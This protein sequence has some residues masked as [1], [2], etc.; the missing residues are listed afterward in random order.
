MS[1][2]DSR[3]T[4]CCEGDEGMSLDERIQQLDERI[5][6]RFKDWVKD[7]HE[8][9]SQ[10]L[11]DEIARQLE[12]A[13]NQV[14]EGLMDLEK[15]QSITAVASS[16]GGELVLRNL[17]SAMVG[18]DRSKKQAD[19]LQALLEGAGAF[20]S[21][22]AIFLTRADQAS[23]W[24]AAGFGEGDVAI[25]GLLVEYQDDGPWDRLSQGRSSIRLSAADCGQ[26]CSRIEA[27]LPGNGVLIPLVLRDR[28]AAAL[29]AD[30]LQDDPG[31]L[32]VEG[33]QLLAYAAAQ[34]IENLPFHQRTSTTP[35]LVLDGDEEE[36]QE[37]L[38]LWEGAAAAVAVSEVE[39]EPTEVEVAIEADTVADTGVDLDLDIETDKELGASTDRAEES[40]PAY[41]DTQELPY[42]PPVGEEEAESEAAPP[43]ETEAAE[44]VV[45]EPA[46]SDDS[47]AE[48]R[49]GSA[50][51]DGVST[52]KAVEPP[53]EAGRG[54]GL[55]WTEDDDVAEPAEEVEDAW[56]VDVTPEVE[57]SEPGALWEVEEEEAEAKVEVIPEAE[58]PPPAPS[59]E[60]VDEPSSVQ[61]VSEAPGLET[62]QAPVMTSGADASLLE[63]DATVFLSR[64]PASPAPRQEPEEAEDEGDETHPG[65][66]AV[67]DPEPAPAPPKP[68]R[69]SEVQPPADVEGPGWAFSKDTEKATDDDEDHKQAKRLARLLVSEIK[70]YNEEQVE[71]GQKNNDIYERLKEDIDRSRQV[72]EDRVNERVRS[73][74]DYF[75]QEL[76]RTL[77]G[78]DPQALGI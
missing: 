39:E 28:V 65:I 9:L 8:Q 59:W 29:Y 33:L 22:L 1:L 7:L 71:Q 54:V 48:A 46:S 78:G 51:S 43:A 24:A 44:D 68:G 3:R 77:A 58:V 52:E 41:Q 66:A 42:P 23:G 69:A 72:Y 60:V 18:I 31:G 2:W 37:G 10:T 14:P 74:N 53:T 19:I 73:T 25:P 15:L 6:S 20:A 4:G 13:T 16:V 32:G 34:A 35:T 76:V 5:A 27:P 55:A 56:A 75:Y 70:L 40:A 49:E 57:G 47:S 11:N 50:E 62:I 17:H 36:E 21:R 64:P 61:S 38:G 30:R 26:L 67:P 63:D 12:E 45:E